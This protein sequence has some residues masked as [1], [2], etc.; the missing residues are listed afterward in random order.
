MA[1]II[2]H[3]L[4][5][6]DAF[7]LAGALSGV[8]VTAIAAMTV[9]TTGAIYAMPT[10]LIAT[11][12][13]LAV[14]VYRKP[15]EAIVAAPVFLMAAGILLPSESRFFDINNPDAWQIHVWAFGLFLI[16]VGAFLKVG[17]KI[18]FRLPISLQGFLVVA[19]L[20]A[21]Y[22][23]AIGNLPSFV[24]RQLFGS[25]LLGAYFALALRGL[26]EE[27]FLRALR[28]CGVGCVLA[29]CV[30]Y[31]WVFDQYGIHKEMIPLPTHT[32][33]LAILFA[34][35]RG[36]RWW[37]AAGIMQVVPL[38]VI[39][40]RDL[41]TFALGVV[42][43]CALSA[44]LRLMR[45]A[46]WTLAGLIIV[47]SLVP[48]YVG[49]VFDAM[50]GTRVFELIPEGS[51][52]EITVEQRG[53]Q[54]VEAVAV[55]QRSPLLGN[56]LG[57]TL[58]WFDRHLGSVRQMYI[59]NGWAY[60]L[61][62]MGLVGVLAFLWFGINVVRWMPGNSIPLTACV[63]SMLTLLLFVEPVF[64]NYITAPLAGAVTGTLYRN[65]LQR[66]KR[67]TRAQAA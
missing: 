26:D 54:F 55:V 11:A 48:S 10:L 59:E 14:R 64:L 50:T 19:L 42:L 31:A 16:T 35:R 3:R 12:I 53:L 8:I 63:L 37:L 43:I 22:G 5:P 4:A 6:T 25:L 9:A 67:F 45:W 49:V 13:F 61:T 21:A 15:E 18:L 17:Y 34:G 57:G 41:A 51:K 38:L 24:F 7:K 33:I 29:F 56:G 27:R 32:T 1:E 44:K 30:Y 58:N 23:L 28:F 40:R 36:W 62:K 60:L 66:S 2:E 47:V 65:W 46:S 52:D 20:A 39:A